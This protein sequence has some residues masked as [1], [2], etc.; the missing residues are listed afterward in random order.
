MTEIRIWIRNGTNQGSETHQ[1]I[2]KK[3]IFLLFTILLT[4][5]SVQNC[6]MKNFL[7]KRGEQFPQCP[8]TTSLIRGKTTWWKKIIFR[9]K[10]VFQK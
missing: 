5:F 3:I 8:M 6:K 9:Q 10:F 1:K 2:V 4:T 7:V